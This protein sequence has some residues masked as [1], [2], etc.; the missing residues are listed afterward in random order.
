MRLTG[1]GYAPRYFGFFSVLGFRRF[2]GEST[3]L[4]IAGNASRYFIKN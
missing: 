4:P 1:D 3:L 2:D